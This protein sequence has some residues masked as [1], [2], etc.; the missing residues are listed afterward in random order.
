MNDPLQKKILQEIRKTSLEN[1]EEEIC[2]LIIDCFDGFKFLPCENLS[3]NKKNTFLIDSRE[4][5][6]Y[7]IKYI[8][9]SHTIGSSLPSKADQ[10][11]CDEILIP[12]LIYSNRHNTFHV[13][14]NNKVKE[15]K[16]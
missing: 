12:F 9:H 5:I 3:K 8:V 11:Y 6:K 2:G 4:I 13:Y 16:V 10:L 15:Y 7:N 14:Y 1:L